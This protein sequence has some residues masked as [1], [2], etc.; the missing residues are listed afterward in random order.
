MLNTSVGVTQAR[1]YYRRIIAPWNLDAATSYPIVPEKGHPIVALSLGASDQSGGV[2]VQT[3]DVDSAGSG[4][5]PL[6]L[7]PWSPLRARLIKPFTVIPITTVASSALTTINHTLELYAW[8]EMPF[9]FSPRGVSYVRGTALPTIET[10]VLGQNLA[11]VSGRKRVTLTVGNIGVGGVTDMHIY[12]LI[13]TTVGT[14]YV[15]VYS[16]A[17]AA[18]QGA[19]LEFNSGLLTATSGGSPGNPITLNYPTQ[20]FAVMMGNSDASNSYDWNV[21]ARDY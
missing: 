17:L 1:N 11:F 9:A 15:R 7:D 20:M 10:P 8:Y 19:I 4:G 16:A 13:P 3:D 12:V 2:L 14:Q 6:A 21:E 18:G 5:N